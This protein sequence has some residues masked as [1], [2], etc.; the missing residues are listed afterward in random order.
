M[1]GHREHRARA[2]NTPVARS[3]RAAGGPPPCHSD[4]RAD[5]PKVRTRHVLSGSSI[6]HSRSAALHPQPPKVLLATAHGVRHLELFSAPP[7]APREIAVP[8]SNSRSRGGRGD[9]EPAHGFSA[10]RSKNFDDVDGEARCAGGGSST[11]RVVL[12]VRRPS[13]CLRV[14]LLLSRDQGAIK[15]SEILNRS[16]SLTP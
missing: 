2:T 9:A 5:G 13:Q 16:R 12:R 7:R 14:N 10:G 6:G 3:S 15:G 4:R 11:R 8:K 1:F